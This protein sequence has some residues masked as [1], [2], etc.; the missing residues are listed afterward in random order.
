MPVALVYCIVLV[1]RV[2]CGAQP[3]CMSD[4]NF[5]FNLYFSRFF[6]FVSPPSASVGVG[7]PDAALMLMTP[8]QYAMTPL[9][10]A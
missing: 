3:L 5:H 2:A 10:Y 9:R 4:V 1:R 7:T 6:S 8:L